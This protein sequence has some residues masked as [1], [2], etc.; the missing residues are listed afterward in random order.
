M[1]TYY[2]EL[3]EYMK[4]IKPISTH[5]HHRP[6]AMFAND[7]CLKTLLEE[8]Y[9]NWCGVEVGDTFE[10]R[11]YYFD[12]IKNRNFFK[13][14][15]KALQLIYKIDTPLRADTYEIFDFAVRKAHR[16]DPDFHMKLL[17][18]I[19][20][21]DHVILDSYWQPG[22][23]GGH[24]ELFSPTFR[25][26][27]FFFGFNPELKDHD[28]N[29]CGKFFGDRFGDFDTF[30]MSLKEL[31]IDSHKRG[32]V[33]IKCA[34][35]YDRGLDFEF[36]TEKKA[37][38]VFEKREGSYD[39]ADVKAF[40]DYIFLQT[41]QIAAEL[42]I[43]FQVHTGLGRL[44][45]TNAY[46]LQ[47]VIEAN[48]DTRFVLFHGGYPWM[49]DIFGLVHVYPKNVF[50]DIVWLPLISTEAAVRMLTELI[51]VANSQSI[52]WG[53]D[54]WTSEESYGALM[55]VR[56]VLAMVLSNKIKDGYMLPA[57]A[58]EAASNILRNNAQRIYRFE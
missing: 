5:C 15:E 36:V 23:N 54:T 24:P 44:S 37:R 49:D 18:D 39:I 40:Q 55:A 46:L 31:I 51:E 11:K 34:T 9:S 33:A 50:P 30:F 3:M 42:D 47:P 41:C 2:Y 12:L 22:E 43:P 4:A 21:Y 45:K 19:A 1:S 53:D 17:T 35:P 8:S 58:F 20:G 57:D 10:S 6:D 7:F 13:C 16:E 52:C 29:N 25:I 32:A 56:H 27:S 48:P 26:D 14:L 28:G 38:K